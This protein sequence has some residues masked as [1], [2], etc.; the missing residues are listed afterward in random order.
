MS[1]FDALGL[2]G[3]VAILAAYTLL[4]TG[5]MAA[6]SLAYSALNAVGALLVLVSLWFDFNLSAAVVEGAWLLISLYGLARVAR[7]AGTP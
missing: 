3:V 4:Q 6:T 1:W 2:V 5:R 7:R